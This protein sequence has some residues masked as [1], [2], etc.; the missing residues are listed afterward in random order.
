[1]QA[2]VVIIPELLSHIFDE[3]KNDTITFTLNDLSLYFSINANTGTITFAVNYDVDNESMPSNVLLDVIATDSGLLSVHVVVS[4]EILDKNEAPYFLN[5]PREIMVIENSEPGS[6]I[7]CILTEDPE[8][9]HV[10]L[11]AIPDEGDWR[12]LGFN[13][14]SKKL[15][16]K[17]GVIMLK[18][19][20]SVQYPE[21]LIFSCICLLIS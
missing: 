5:L 10:I 12:A 6:V 2:G 15:R 3:D 20:L 17:D 16:H 7:Y 14:S 13:E 1:M 18:I 8:R 21:N 11:R 4:I 9:H 19:F